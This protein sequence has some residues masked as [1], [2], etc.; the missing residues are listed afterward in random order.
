M[1]AVRPRNRRVAKLAVVL[2]A[3]ALFGAPT[4]LGSARDW[5]TPSS[6]PPGW[7]RRTMVRPWQICWALAA[8]TR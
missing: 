8:S 4:G 1:T 3:A 2:L 7:V 5:A 6:T